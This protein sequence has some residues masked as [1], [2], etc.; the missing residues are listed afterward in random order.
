MP[1]LYIVVKNQ[2]PQEN[3]PYNWL[4]LEGITAA[5]KNVAAFDER[6]DAD[7][8]A[9]HHNNIGN[10]EVDPISGLTSIEKDV[11][12]A[13]DSA[14]NAFLVL[15][16]VRE[17]NEADFRHAIHLAESVI[18]GRIVARIFPRWWR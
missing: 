2:H 18:Q 3:G 12:D 15:R 13:L 17:E 6:A 4:V 8:Y 16:N 1:A 11:C 7:M 5:G 14:W 9:N 10:K